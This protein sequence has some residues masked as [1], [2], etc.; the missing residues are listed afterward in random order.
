[1]EITDISEIVA[2]RSEGTVFDGRQGTLWEN[3]SILVHDRKGGTYTIAPDVYSQDKELLEIARGF[4]G[5]KRRG[6]CPW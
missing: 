2:L 6:P 4:W 3:D 1:M 5:V